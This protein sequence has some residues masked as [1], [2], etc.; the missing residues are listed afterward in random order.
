MKT[1]F[2]RPSTLVVSP[3]GLRSTFSTPPMF[4]LGHFLAE[5]QNTHTTHEARRTNIFKYHFP[6]SAQGQHSQ[7]FRG[8]AQRP[9]GL[10]TFPQLMAQC[11]V[12]KTCPVRI[13]RSSPPYSSCCSAGA[14]KAAKARFLGL[15][16]PHWPKR[17]CAFL[18][19]LT[20]PLQ[21]CHDFYLCLSL[22][23][24][25]FLCLCV[26]LSLYLFRCQSPQLFLHHCGHP[27]RIR[28]Y[29]LS[30]FL[31]SNVVLI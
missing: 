4:S 26:T 13:A 7:G 20:P 5:T 17:T 15:A 1:G 12:S 19:F 6:F 14:G 24:R 2:G 16:F 8:R 27:S 10:P 18:C 9:R 3:R 25:L 31:K 11:F 30:D 23:P 21:L 22:L 28:L 29:T